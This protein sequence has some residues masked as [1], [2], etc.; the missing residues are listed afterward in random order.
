MTR[1]Q[2]FFERLGVKEYDTRYIQ[3]VPI[4]FVLGCTAT[5]NYSNLIQKLPHLE[6]SW[7]NANAQGVQAQDS[8]DRE[9]EINMLYDIIE[10]DKRLLSR[11]MRPAFYE[12]KMIEKE[13]IRGKV[14]NMSDFQRNLLYIIFG[15]IILG[16]ILLLFQS[17]QVPAELSEIG[18]NSG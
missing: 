1:I 12:T 7:V 17:A 14:S 16:T 15:S 10:N 13:G 4:Y 11:K 5:A 9:T 2:E 18:A 8:S 6:S 3:S